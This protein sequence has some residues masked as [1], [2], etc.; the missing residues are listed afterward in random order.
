MLKLKPSNLNQIQKTLNIQLAKYAKVSSIDEKERLAKPRS[1]IKGVELLRNPSLYKGMAFTID[2]RQLLGIHGL[3]PPAVLSQEVQCLRI[4]ENFRR[5][6]D[7][8]DR[9]I[10]LI[11]LQYRNEK[12]F[13]KVLK[14]NLELLMPIV[15]TPTVGLACQK[16][17]I[18]FRRSKGLF[19][20]IHDKGHIYDVLCNWPETTVK[21]IVVT[22]G[23]RIL[24][25]G[26]LGCYGMGIPVGKLS[27][28]TALAG[29]YPTHCLPIMLDVGTNNKELLDDPLYIGLRQE[30]VGGK[31]YEEFMDEF[32]DAVV[33]RFGYNCLIQFEDFASHNA[34]KFLEKYRNKY[35][36]FNDDIQGTAAVALAGVLT[37][38]RVS[39]IDLQDNRILFVGAGQAACGIAELVALA[40]SRKANISIDEACERIYMFDVDGLLVENRPEGQLDGPKNKFVKT[41]FTPTRDLLN[42]VEQVKPT[43]LIG[44]TGVGGIFTESVLKKMG[45]LNH[46]PI[47]F[48]LSNPTNKAECTAEQAFR[49]TDG[50]CLFSSGSPFNPVEYNGKTYIPGQGNNSYIFPGVALATTVFQSKHIDEEVFLIAAESLSEQVSEEDLST[51]RIYPPMKQIQDVSVKIATEVSKYYYSVGMASLYP[52]PECLETH[53]RNQLYDTTYQSYVPSTWS[54][55]EEHLK[56]KNCDQSSFYEN[57]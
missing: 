29:I 4:M 9:Y 14:D 40:I 12:L 33:A 35:C 10:S 53:I 17:G 25:L 21:A 41:N 8:L 47:I 11:N 34:H 37:S 16:Y 31:V 24:G 5:E 28:Y 57:D 6:K 42:A 30:R 52:K 26:D 20:T 3:L 54:W 22:D 45:E 7:D 18:A 50:R 43:V 38:L 36:M 27:L 49:N 46:R 55:P 1:Q 13:Y 51:G 44:A 15:Y 2:E 39:G 23:Q 32:M 56:P 19:I 48:A